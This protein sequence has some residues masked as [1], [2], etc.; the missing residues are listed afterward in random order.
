[1]EKILEDMDIGIYKELEKDLEK[2]VTAITESRYSDV[3][4][5]EGLPQGFVRADGEV[6]LYELLSHG[7]KDV[8]GLALRLSMAN[9]FL[10]D[11]EGFMA[12]DDPLVNLDHARQ[13]RAAEIIKVYADEKQVL[14]F[15]CHP[16]N[17]ELLGGH[18]ITL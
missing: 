1:M 8:L 4:L 17:A 14:V 13:R 3:K 7:T 9:H 15:T 18:K 2:Y 6:V 12:M 10:R 5:K 11:A 16:A